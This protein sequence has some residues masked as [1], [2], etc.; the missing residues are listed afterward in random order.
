M[1]EGGLVQEDVL[2]GACVSEHEC[3][4]RNGFEAATTATKLLKIGELLVTRQYDVV[5][6]GSRRLFAAE[7]VCSRATSLSH[8]SGTQLSLGFI[9]R[10]M[11]LISVLQKRTMS[12]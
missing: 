3:N 2:K 1:S 10:R 5:Q 9:R 8:E 7:Q 11:T 6:V 12:S 4:D